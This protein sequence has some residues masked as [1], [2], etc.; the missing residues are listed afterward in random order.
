MD[1]PKDIVITDVLARK[2]EMRNIR[3]V[4]TWFATEEGQ[5]YLAARM[6]EWYKNGE[7]AFSDEVPS[8]EIWERIQERTRLLSLRSHLLLRYAAVLIPAIFLVGIL[9]YM[10]KRVDL[11]GN[12]PLVEVYV[13]KGEKTHLVFQDGTSVYLGP[14][15]R[16]SYPGKFGIWERKVR[17]SGEAYFDVAKGKDWPFVVEVGDTRIKVLGTSFNLMAYKDSPEIK[18]RL[19]E[20]VIKFQP[21]QGG[22]EFLLSPGE[23]V[24]F[25]KDNGVVRIDRED[26]ESCWV[27]WKN[28]EI[29]FKDAPL[30]NLL[31]VLS[32]KFNV[33]FVIDDDKIREFCYTIRLDDK[34]LK[35]I[36]DNL[37]NITPVRFMAR[38]DSIHVVMK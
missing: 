27:D 13:P 36:L 19:D 22:K 29:V 23:S 11:L 12:S 2:S 8:R 38:E 7:P 14:D 32:R 26:D 25:G 37:E 17:F 15:S 1:R 35:T 24:S 9:Q 21:A 5:A 34:P 6:D 31:D 16:L 33:T 3:E 28:N 10:G 30:E 4:V 20:G 18:I